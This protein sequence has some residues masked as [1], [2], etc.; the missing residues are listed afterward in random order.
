MDFP[1]QR[2]TQ[3]GATPDE[4]A[5]L[6][7]RFSELPA[8][9]KESELERIAS[10]S[11]YDLAAELEQLRAAEDPPSDELGGA[12]GQGEPETLQG[13][14][15][16]PAKTANPEPAPLEPANQAVV[17]D[18]D[19]TGDGWHEITGTAPDQVTD[20]KLVD[21]DGTVTVAA[22]PDQPADACLNIAGATPDSQVV[23]EY[24][25]PAAAE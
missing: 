24:H 17:I 21:G 19:A 9:A 7:A 2:Y 5:A 6:E 18:I 3:A 11:D 12:D 4:L 25:V 8:A 13:V 22:V 10:I 15:E 23:V 1:A 20:V 14:V 16:P